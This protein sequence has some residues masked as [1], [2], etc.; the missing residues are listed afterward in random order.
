VNEG[1]PATP[2]VPDPLT[3]TYSPT[4]RDAVTAVALT[5]TSDPARAAATTDDAIRRLK[6]PNRTKRMIYLARTKGKR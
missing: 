2:S 3:L 4:T 1:P 6:E 5:A